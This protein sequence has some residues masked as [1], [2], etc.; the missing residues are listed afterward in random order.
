MPDEPVGR[1][2]LTSKNAG[3]AYQRGFGTGRVEYLTIVSGGA[4]CECPAC[5]LKSISLNQIADLE[6]FGL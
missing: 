2:N 4:T 5:Q 3:T 1:S 6:F